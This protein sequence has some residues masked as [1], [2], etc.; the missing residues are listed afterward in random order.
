VIYGKDDDDDDDDD[1]HLLYFGFGGKTLLNHS[2]LYRL[3]TCFSFT[4]FCPHFV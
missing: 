4:Y 2:L 1:D 3:I